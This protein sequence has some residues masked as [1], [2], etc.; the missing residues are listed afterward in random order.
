MA[1][2][3]GI[4]DH[5]KSH[6]A[7]YERTHP[8]GFRWLH[9]SLG[10]NWRLTEMQSAI[11]RV[12]LRKLDAWLERRA[13]NAV[14]LTERLGG[15]PALR[16]PVPGP[17]IRHA[18]YQWYSFVRPEALAPGW[19]RDRIMVEVSARGVACFAGACPE[20]YREAAMRSGPR[21]TERLPVARELG[22]TSLM[23][24]VHPTLD[25]DAMHRAADAMAEVLRAATR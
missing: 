8:P 7:V 23:L 22:E 13:R 2:R 11:G 14:I 16:V 10:T 20:I 5:G 4:K 1:P 18:W 24:L 17:G 15:L 21:A 12:Q 25:D 6:A 19:D 9:E 3:L